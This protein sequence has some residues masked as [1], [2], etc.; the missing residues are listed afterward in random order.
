MLLGAQ[1]SSMGCLPAASFSKNV[2]SIPAS[3]NTNFQC[4]KQE[5]KD[6]LKKES[7]T[8][9]RMY[10]IPPRVR[11]KHDTHAQPLLLRRIL[12]V[13]AKV[14]KFRG[15]HMGAYGSLSG[16]CTKRNCYL[17]AGVGTFVLYYIQD[18]GG[19]DEK[20][21]WQLIFNQFNISTRLDF[22]LYP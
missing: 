18:V 1:T 20:A 7:G 10:Y 8:T 16:A 22:G 2:P 19:R 17:G 3:V 6:K 9:C 11:Q 5:S 4:R 21:C 12:S 14:E 15:K 13:V